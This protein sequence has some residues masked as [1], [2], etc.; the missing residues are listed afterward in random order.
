MRPAAERLRAREPRDLPPFCAGG[1]GG[2]AGEAGR[3][4]PRE[5]RLSGNWAPAN[6]Y[7]KQCLRQSDGAKDVYRRRASSAPRSRRDEMNEGQAYSRAADKSEGKDPDWR[8]SSF[9]YAN[10]HFYDSLRSWDGKTDV[11]SRTPKDWRVSAADTMGMKGGEGAYGHDFSGNNADDWKRSSPVWVEKQFRQA[12][13]AGYEGKDVALDGLGHLK[14]ENARQ[15]AGLINGGPLWREQKKGNTFSTYHAD[16]V[17]SGMLRSGGSPSAE[18]YQRR[19]RCHLNLPAF[20]DISAEVASKAKR[21][22]AQIDLNQDG[23]ISADE[24][25][26]FLKI[27]GHKVEG[28][29]KAIQ[30]LIKAADEG[31][32][33]CK[34]Q[35]MEF[36]RLYNGLKLDTK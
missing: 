13:A 17:F 19:R 8:A 2:T 11:A 16:E 33:D 9:R 30:D 7:F 20:K 25:A 18:E 21:L 1:P 6:N 27:L 23:A 4:T 31:A 32:P 34:L 28:G 35:V 5:T 29:P 3:A 24:L 22:F 14:K 26:K 10:A 15:K 36:V 12:M